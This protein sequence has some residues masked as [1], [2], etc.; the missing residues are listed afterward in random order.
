M[1]DKT[2]TLKEK[3]LKG[4]EESE[5]VKL[6]LSKNPFIPFIPKDIQGTF[7]NREKEMVLLARYLPELIKEFMPLL[8]LAGTKGVGKTH[9]LNYIF[10]QLQEL[11][12]EIG[13]DVVFIDVDKF[14]EFFNRVKVGDIKRPQLVLIDDTEKVWENYKESFVELVDSFDKIKIIS[15]WTSSKWTKS[16]LDPFYS[17]LKPACIPINKLTDG[18]LIKIVNMRIQNSLLAKRERPFSEE[19]LIYLAKVSEGV[20]YTMVYFCEKMLHH[21][22][23]NN[24]SFA[25]EDVTKKFVKS[26][27]LKKFDISRF[28]QTQLSVLKSLLEITNSK[29]R[30]ATS[31]E[32][33]D[34]LEIKRP[35]AIEHLRRLSEVVESNTLDKKKLY[36]IKPVLMSHV[37]E[38]FAEEG[39][40]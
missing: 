21:L 4:L 6:G 3:V 37:E 16:K 19:S 30:G 25:N 31:T 36:F 40:E 33:A 7:I 22:L 18:H 15:V 20:P 26:L 32:I 11:G 34:D 29:K 13:H 23:D 28:T 12:E 9:F 1:S 5:F 35:T 39:I 17:S 27:N 8:V 14:E 24:L 2:Y 38:I 10:E